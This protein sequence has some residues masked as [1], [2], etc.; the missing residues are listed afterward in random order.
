MKKLLFAAFIALSCTPLPPPV[1]P[2]LEASCAGAEQNLT[3]IGGCTLDVAGF[4]ER[5]ESAARADAEVGVTSDVACLAR[6]ETC[7][8][9]LICP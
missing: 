4:A 1:S 3:R 7:E 8:E 5:C 9:F 6:A 2:E